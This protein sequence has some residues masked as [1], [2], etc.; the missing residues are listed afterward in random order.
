LAAAVPSVPRVCTAGVSEAEEE[1]A[2][3]PKSRTAK[4]IVEILTGVKVKTISLKEIVGDTDRD[5]EPGPVTEPGASASPEENW[6]AEYESHETRAE[7]QRLSFTASGVTR[8]ADG[9]EINFS[10]SVEM[11]SEQVSRADV[12]ARFGNARK[13]DPLVINFDGNAAQL[14]PGRFQFD[15][16]ADGTQ[17]GV[18]LLAPGSA[19]L[20][21]DLDGDG[22]ITN[23]RELFGPTTGNGM[24]ELAVHDQDGNGWIDER[25]PVYSQL[26]IWTRDSSGQD[27]LDS[28][29]D[30]DV[31]AIFLGY[32]AADF[33]MKTTAGENLGTTSRLGIYLREDGRA[34]AVQQIDFVV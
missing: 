16:D 2:L 20:A 25:D 34:G 32:A 14:T 24:A 17:D 30:R 12:F 11:R 31:G 1:A 13:I 23:G 18:P 10:F 28:L 5:F 26:L 19:F 33:Q 21:L 6:G 22:R 27:R 4:L 7:I 9:K 15:L 29:R 8:T 3:D